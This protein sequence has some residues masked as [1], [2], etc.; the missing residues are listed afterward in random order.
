MSEGARRDFEI[1]KTAL[2]TGGGKRIGRA[3]C[4]A[5][6]AHGWSIAVHYH[7]S[8]EEAEAACTE[9]RAAGAPKAAAI[10]GD[11]ADAG[12]VARLLPAAIQALGDV[13]LLVKS[14]EVRARRLGDAADRPTRLAYK[15]LTR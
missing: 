2:V 5:L 13:G 6:A 10:Q 15:K 11:L 14:A 7:E 12:A 3:I 4:D 1:P 8:E 9:L